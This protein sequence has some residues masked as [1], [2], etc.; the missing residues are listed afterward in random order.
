MKGL[1]AILGLIVLA[2]SSCMRVSDLKDN[3]TFI[4]PESNFTPFNEAIKE[5]FFKRGNWPDSTW[6]TQFQSQQLDLLMQEAL[7]NNPTLAAFTEKVQVVLE[8]S[9]MAKAP[10]F[11]NLF[12]NMD[13]QWGRVSKNGIPYAYNPSLGSIYDVVE[14]RFNFKYEIDFWGKNRNLLQA[15]L[16]QLQSSRADRAQAVL[17]VSTSLAKAYFALQANHQRLK[18]YEQL[19][20]VRYEKLRL[21]ELLNQRGLLSRIDPATAVEEFEEVNKDIEAIKKEIAQ[22]VYTLN[23]LRG[24]LPDQELLIQEEFKS[25][26]KSCQLPST[27]S[28]DL[29]ARRP[30]L[31]AS[32]WHI[33]ALV[34]N[35]NAAVADYFPRVDLMGFL[36]QQSFPFKH[37]F[38]WNSREGQLEPSIHI[39][40]FRAGEIRANHRKRQAELNQAIY[41]Y[42]ELLLRSLKEASDSISFVKQSY[43]QK[44][45]QIEIV[46]Q[47]LYQRKLYQSRQNVGLDGFL[48]VLE[49]EEKVLQNRLQE[50]LLN[51]QQ[52]LSLIQ[53]VKSLGGG[54]FNQDVTWLEG[55]LSND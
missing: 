51:Y 40:I 5:P 39:P 1:V 30:D 25:V 15:A 8:N 27:L 31:V 43:L 26:P 14:F 36:G 10:L 4:H 3:T 9:K 22:D 11:P 44:E 46:K 32:I 23:V 21:I 2:L 42:N 38:D 6:W 34:H 20:Q 55:G 13:E 24:S 49:S 35:L 29:I 54:Y 47:S 52:Y 37:L 45:A 33:Q 48:P 12:F 17:M 7:L 16:D 41:E 50:V 19:L 28:T 53:L 18:L